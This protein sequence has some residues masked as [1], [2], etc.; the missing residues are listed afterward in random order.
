MTAATPELGNED[1]VEVP[2]AATVQCPACG[3][4]AHGSFCCQC[5]TPLAGADARQTPTLAGQYTAD[6]TCN[7]CHKYVPW[8]ARERHLRYC[9]AG[10]AALAEG[11]PLGR[12]RWR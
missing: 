3:A 1:L 12:P 5:G 4:P 8:F 6:G 2:T 9:G 10:T 11:P 7:G